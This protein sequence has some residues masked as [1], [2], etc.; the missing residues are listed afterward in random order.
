MNRAIIRAMPKIAASLLLLTLL[1]AMA[2]TA[3]V[4]IEKTN[5]KG[6]PNC[7]RITNGEVELIVTSDIGP[8][9][10]RYAFVGGPNFFKEFTE[11]LGKSGEPAWGAR[12]GHRVWAAPEDA[13][14]TYAADNGP[15]HIEIKGDVDEATE[16]PEALTGLEKQ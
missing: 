9:I 12:G 15:V 6:W 11:T 16:P 14:R 8:R 1:P 7:Y 2:A 10:M 13:G 4:K 3:A 5:Y